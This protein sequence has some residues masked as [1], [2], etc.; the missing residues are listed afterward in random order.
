MKRF[1]AM[2]LVLALLFSLVVPAAGTLSR[3]DEITRNPESSVYL[4][5]FD[6]VESSETQDFTGE[7]SDGRNV[8]P[9]NLSTHTTRGR[10]VTIFL[11]T[12][13][14]DLFQNGNLP[15]H[16][17]TDVHESRWDFLPIIWGS[18]IGWV[19]GIGDGRFDP[20][21]YMTREEFVTMLGRGINPPNSNIQL[22]FSDANL[23]SWWAVQHVQNAVA[24]GWLFG[25]PDG[26]FRPQ[27]PISRHDAIVLAGRASRKSPTP[28]PTRLLGSP[29]AAQQ[30][31]IGSAFRGWL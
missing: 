31:R 29:M 18:G 25:F 28:C 11:M 6:Y 24:Q 15:A 12:A 19:N 3:D 21:R 4:E 27:D 26:T 17:F 20:D 9:M 5:H 13:R 2:L 16:R 7:F 8:L 14:W 1:L 23:I 22:P 10:A 30:Y